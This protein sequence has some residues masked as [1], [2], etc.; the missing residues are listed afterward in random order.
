MLIFVT[1]YLGMALL[2]H[3]LL[4][5]TTGLVQLAQLEDLEVQDMGTVAQDMVL[6]MAKEHLRLLDMAHLKFL[7]LVNS[8]DNLA[9]SSSRD[10]SSNLLR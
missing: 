4:C 5:L 6:D 7:P 10:N 2:D 9:N 1:I 8:R 3:Q